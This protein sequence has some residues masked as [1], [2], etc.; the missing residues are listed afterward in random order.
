MPQSLTAKWEDTTVRSIRIFH[1][2]KGLN[3]TCLKPSHL[4]TITVIHR[5]MPLRASQKEGLYSSPLNISRGMFYKDLSPP[6]R[7][8]LQNL[9]LNTKSAVP[10][11]GD[12][13]PSS[14][15][16]GYFPAP[17]PQFTHYP[18]TGLPGPPT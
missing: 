17:L 11:A 6:L 13:F 12:A 10:R 3:S 18:L 1:L 16:G 9:Q 8:Q 5:W 7:A 15:R 4:G 14:S 2:P